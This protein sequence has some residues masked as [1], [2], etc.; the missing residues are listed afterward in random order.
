MVLPNCLD[1]TELPPP[2][3]RERLILFAGRVV[4][5]KGPDA[6]V[7]AC[8]AALPHLP[9]W[10]AEIIGADRFSF[11]SPDTGFVQMIR[12]AAEA[13]NVRMLGYR[14]HPEV[15]A[16]MARAAIV[17]VPSRWAGTVRAGRAGGAGERRGADLLPA[18][19][20]ARGRRRCR[21]ICRSRSPS[22]IAAAIRD[23]AGDESRRAALA[24]AG[25][26]RAQQ[27][28]VPAIAARLADLRREICRRV[29][30][31]KASGLCPR[32][33]KGGAFAII[34]LRYARRRGPTRWLRGRRETYIAGPD[35]LVRVQGAWPLGGIEG[36][37][38]SPCCLSPDYQRGAG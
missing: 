37:G 26:Q 3:Q 36:Q 16:A 28:D 34:T 30:E 29:K 13:A 12:A 21:G 25:R 10:G 8:A 7:S 38:P 33:S 32:P 35:T 9:G 11:D 19:R 27:F 14:D 17:V 24:E 6:F 1:L 23:L 2:R 5:D 15:L 4:A 20:P 22:E 31:S 18:R